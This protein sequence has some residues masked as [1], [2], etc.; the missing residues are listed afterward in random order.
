MKI[1]SFLMGSLP[2][3]VFSSTM[4][5]LAHLY[6]FRHLIDFL[7]NRCSTHHQHIHVLKAFTLEKRSASFEKKVRP[8]NLTQKDNFLLI[9]I[10]NETLK[11]F[12]LP[13]KRKFSFITD[14]LHFCTL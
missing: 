11:I 6:V 7:L 9:N 14:D 2:L 8:L 4:M 12:F 3:F 13:R 1:D 10:L 5:G